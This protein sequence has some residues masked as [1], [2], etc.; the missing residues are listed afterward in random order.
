VTTAGDRIAHANTSQTPVKGDAL[1]NAEQLSPHAYRT[2][3]TNTKDF[4]TT[5]QL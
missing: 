4:T 3:K 1:W 2:R 5:A